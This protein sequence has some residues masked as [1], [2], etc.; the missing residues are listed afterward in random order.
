MEK[1][2]HVREVSIGSEVD[3]RGLLVEHCALAQVPRDEGDGVRFECGYL[4]VGGVDD[5][6]LQPEGDIIKVAAAISWLGEYCSVHYTRRARSSVQA[7]ST[8]R[9]RRG[10]RV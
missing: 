8:S 2:I 7:A 3:L 4:C 6:E 9:G 5:H 1:K 10:M